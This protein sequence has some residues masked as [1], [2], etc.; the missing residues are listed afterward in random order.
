MNSGSLTGRLGLIRGS[1]NKLTKK[2][3]KKVLSLPIPWMKVSSYVSVKETVVDLNV[4]S[5]LP[6]EN[7]ASLFPELQN[8]KLS[9]LLFYDL[10]TTGLSGGAGTVAFLAGFGWIKDG[11]FS[12]KQFFLHDFPGESDFLQSIGSVLL[13]GKVLVS[14]NGK[15]FDHPLLRTRFLMNGLNLDSIPEVDLLH[16]S[17]RL[18]KSRLSSCRLGTVEE[19]I[20]NISRS[21]DIPGIYIPDV[22]FN[23]LKSNSYSGGTFPLSGVF[24]HHLQDIKSLALLLIHIIK[25]WSNPGSVCSEDAASLG[26]LMLLKKREEG[27]LLLER[28]WA[29]GENEVGR[30]LSL[31]YKR[32]GKLLEAVKIWKV[33]WKKSEELFA[34]LEL[35][36]YYEHRIKNI[37]AAKKIVGKLICK[38]DIVNNLNLVKRL[39]YRMARLY[40]KELVSKHSADT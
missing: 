12:I 20:L 18:W 16:T 22:Y 1:K 13:P 27:V 6:G 26:K 39:E 21:N 19:N 11:C 30:E 15:S 17:R 36:K 37:D 33:M 32:S 14:Y 38:P 31:Y 25:I 34:G 8:V 40:R 4:N 35:A 3:N 28:C 29:Q 24:D 23:Y 5:D 7:I 9:D 2:E 10:E